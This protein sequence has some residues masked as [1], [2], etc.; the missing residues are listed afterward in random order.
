MLLVLLPPLT[1]IIT[2]EFSKVLF[3]Q[4]QIFYGILLIVGGVIAE[5][6]EVINLINKTKQI[7]VTN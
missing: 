2:I 4:G 6:I 3:Q 5:V 7:F 1:L